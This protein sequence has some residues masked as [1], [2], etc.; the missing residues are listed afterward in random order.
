MKLLVTCIL[1]YCFLSA[2]TAQW[3]WEDPL[4]QGHSLFGI[5]TLGDGSVLAIGSSATL[6][7]HPDD[8]SWVRQEILPEPAFNFI[9]IESFENADDVWL[10]GT[11][12]NKSRTYHFDGQQWQ[13]EE[14]L[15]GILGAA[16]WLNAGEGWAVGSAGLIVHY[17]SAGWTPVASSTGK[18]LFDVSFGD[19]DHGWAVGDNGTILFYNGIEWAQQ[20]SPTNEQIWKVWM[21]SAGE[22]WAIAANKK[23]LHF[24]G[25]SWSEYPL[26]LSFQPYTLFFLNQNTGWIAGE[27]GNILKYSNGNW[28]TENNPGSYA[29][30]NMWMT[31]ENTGWA[32]GGYQILEK[33]NGAWINHS[34]SA[35]YNDQHISIDMLNENEGWVVGEKGMILHKNGGDW[36]K[37]PSPTSKQLWDVVFPLPDEGWCVG[38][39]GTILKYTGP[40]GWQ[41]FS[42]PVSTR[43]SEAFFTQ[44]ADGWA[45]G[46]EGVILHYDG[47]HWVQVPSPTAQY[48]YNVYFFDAEHGWAVGQ[49]AT[50]L[51]YLDGQWS[52]YPIPYTNHLNSVVQTSET[53]GWI[54][55]LPNFLLRFDGSDWNPVPSPV[56]NPAGDLPCITCP[57]SGVCYLLPFN[58]NYIYQWKND[59][60]NK[61]QQPGGFSN[62]RADFVS[63]DVG[64]F[65]GIGQIIKF[66]AGGITDSKSL[67]N[68]Y[69]PVPLS[70]FPNPANG[71]L[72]TRIV[73]SASADWDIRL[74][75]LSGAVCRTLQRERL[76]PG[77]HLREHF[78]G[79]VPAGI[80]FLECR[81][82]QQRSV[83]KVVIR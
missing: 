71:S 60:W 61:I 6:L 30:R 31:D 48:L 32:V 46:E 67:D 63:A 81:S 82:D 69:I 78:I 72:F 28:S 65:I 35:D 8:S 83:Q 2:V 45:V 22:G 37:Y 68:E 29:I 12:Y 24:D 75:S 13:P 56:P 17:N 47:V 38:D 76:D 33:K 41:M 43:L 54:T 27:S 14:E 5:C 21:I 66:N 34:Q 19:A 44:P 51:R 26:T 1:S 59:Q 64:Y 57:E 79:D 7:Y 74:L 4:P 80:Y 70:V 3:T 55:G 9:D 18:S 36:E 77:E 50:I 11:N 10:I 42:S 58:R 39:G 49:N 20:A 23:L 52:V 25:V 62:R 40:A 16:D 53:D 73:I 15:N